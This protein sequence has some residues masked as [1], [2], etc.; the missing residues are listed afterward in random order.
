LIPFRALAGK[1][2]T[3]ARRHHLHRM[4]AGPL[5][6]LLLAPATALAQGAPAA[7][8]ATAQMHLSFAAYA[9]G[10]NVIDLQAG[11]DMTPT[12][13]RVAIEFRTTGMFG[14]I[15]HARTESIAAGAWQG[16]GVAPVRFYS[17]GTVRGSPRRTQIDFEHGQPVV[18]ILEPEEDEERDPIPPEQERNTIDTLSAIAKLVHDVLITQHCDGSAT[19]FDGRRVSAIS[20]H[21]AGQEVLDKDENSIFAGPALRCD[22]EGRQ[23]AGFVH[24]VDREE[25]E[26]PQHGSAW[27]APVLPGMPAMP[28]RM[29]FHTRFFGDAI[30]YL[31]EAAPGPLK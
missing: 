14:A 20:V 13:Y 8:G 29:S 16:S 6:I 19:T 4:R 22:F 5:L 23:T 24:N 3:A 2:C 15:I 7:P 1:R 9:A 10:L 25:L 31:T 21:T 30:M 28:V 11:V 12:G 27:L 26:K 17:Y 18:K